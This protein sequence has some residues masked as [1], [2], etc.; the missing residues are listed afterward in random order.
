MEKGYGG[1]GNP[2]A[3]IVAGIAGGAAGA[4]VGGLLVKAGV[5]PT[6]SAGIVTATGGAGAYLLRGYAKSASIGVAASGAGQLALTLMARK[7]A[8]V[9]GRT[10]QTNRRRNELPAPD[11]YAAMEEARREIGPPPYIPPPMRNDQHEEAY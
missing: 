4:A 2:A 6:L 10:L 5:G 1:R 11:V 8:Q 9:Q 3:H 7:P